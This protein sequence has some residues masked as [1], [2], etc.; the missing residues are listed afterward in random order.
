VSTE[1]LRPGTSRRLPV[2]MTDTELLAALRAG[3][4]GAFPELCARHE[5]ALRRTARGILRAN[6]AVVDDV[7]QESLLRAHRALRRDDRHIEVRPYLFRLVRNCCLDEIARSRTDSV[8]LHLLHPGQEP[9]STESVHALLERRDRLTTTLA[10]VADLPESQR[11]ALLRREIDGLTHEQVAAELGVS[12]GASR[13]LVLR[14]RETLTRAAAARG[15]DC[16]D[17]R[18]DLLRA[19]DARHRASVSA[20]RH[21]A[22]C[23]QCRAFRAAL[24]H[25]RRTLRVLAP[26]S[27]LLGGALFGGKAVGLLTGA[28][29]PAGVKAAAVITAAV[30]A[31]GG[32]YE[33][34]TQVF[35]PGERA[36]VSAVGVA[37]PG[38]QLGAGQ[39]LPAHTA[40]V[41]KRVR[42]PRSGP[43]APVTLACPAHM[44]VAG[45]VPEAA[46]GRSHGFDARTVI[47]ASSTAGVQFATRGP[48]A[49]RTVD[50]AILCRE[51][52]PTGSVRAVSATPSGVP[53]VHACRR[54]AALSDSVRGPVLG[55]V[56]SRQPL[57][58]LGGRRGW[59]RVQTDAGRTGWVR[60]QVA[61]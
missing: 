15:A 50:V 43:V 53:L 40:L 1:P 21:V 24:K 58:V 19:H 34:N 20:L 41:T 30:V 39:P 3:H 45:L 47:G 55:T 10:D 42:L 18:A 46:D 56:T 48:D 4:P 44:R 36:P 37:L 31:A 54:R 57:A 32:A 23:S 25:D 60:V 5:P 59:L 12:P 14:A 7:V 33:L 28:S 49:G 2:R 11:H 22:S 35:G 16:E 29:K 8:A 13:S 26:P 61:C 27:L 38:G 6:P 52:D 9:A 51:P 17:V